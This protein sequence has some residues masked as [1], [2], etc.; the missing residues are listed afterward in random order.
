MDGN[1]DPLPPRQPS[2]SGADDLEEDFDGECYFSRHPEEINSDL[3]LGLIEWQ[4]PLPTKMALPSTFAEAELEAL[5]PRKPRALDDESI[6]DY[7]TLDKREE[8]LLSVRQTEV[9]EEVKDDVIYREFPLVCSEILTMFEMIER[10][11][12]RPDPEWTVPPPTK[13]ASQTPE[14][15]KQEANIKAETGGEAMDIQQSHGASGNIQTE[16]S[17]VLGN[18]EQALFAN[19]TDSS[20]NGYQAAAGTT[21]SRTASISSTTGE[22]ITR[23][24]PLA[25][26][27]DRA[28]EDV[29]VALGVTGSPKMV[30]QTPGPAFG[31]PPTAAQQD[32]DAMR[33]SR[34][35][36]ITSNAGAGSLRQPLTDSY[37]TA[38][39][40]SRGSHHTANGSDFQPEDLDATPRPKADRMDNR[41]RSYG[42]VENGRWEADEST[43]KQ[44]RFKQPRVEETY[45]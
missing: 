38:R 15:V 5:A 39:P 19:G 42:E 30:Y 16:D 21:H 34:Q 41:K 28:Q 31:A 18:L 11:R 8:A 32:H 37:A 25:P 3:S 33:M 20:A 13:T 17:D 45:G 23:P 4:A 27:R 43:P 44:Q 35:S 9:W 26:V 7:F 10:Y 40:G 24:K 12:D 36:S 6:S 2:T 29:L 22:R 1:G 14:P